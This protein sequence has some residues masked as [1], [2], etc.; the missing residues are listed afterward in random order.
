MT[1][2]IIL[3]ASGIIAGMGWSLPVMALAYIKSL[4]S[5]RSREDA[6]MRF[7]AEW[8]F[9][10]GILG[11]ITIVGFPICFIFVDSTIVLHFMFL[12]F[13]A[14]VASGL[15]LWSILFRK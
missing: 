15:L 9:V 3:A 2:L 5:K 11:L 7:V 12:Y 6:E 14:A 10:Q 8:I 1:L 13:I 4:F